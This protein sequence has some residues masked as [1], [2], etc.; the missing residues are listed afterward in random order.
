MS[1][2]NSLDGLN[3][4]WDTSEEKVGELEYIDIETI[5]EWSPERG[6]KKTLKM[7]SLRDL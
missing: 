4:Q 5:E 6:E 2:K 1:E 3:I 7:E